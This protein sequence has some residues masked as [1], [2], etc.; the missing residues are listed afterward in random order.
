MASGDRLKKKVAT[1]AAIRLP[2]RRR[3]IWNS[4]NVLAMCT[5]SISTRP[6]LMALPKASNWWGSTLTQPAIISQPAGAWS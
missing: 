6:V 2:E 3:A 4:K 5:S 1:T